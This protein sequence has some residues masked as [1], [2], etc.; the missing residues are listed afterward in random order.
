[1]DQVIDTSRVMI[2]K[3][4]KSFSAASRLFDKSRRRSA[5]MLYAWCRYCDDE[6]D[7]QTLG[8]GADADKAAGMQRLQALYRETLRALAGERVEDAVF[9]ALQRVVRDHEIPDRYPLELLE[10]FAMDVQGQRYRELG[11]TLQYCYHVAGVVGVMMAHVMGVRGRETL[12]R[13]AD[14]GI[15]FQLTNIA[16]DVLDDARMGRCYLPESWLAEEG[17]TREDLLAPGHRA[18]L[19]RVARRLLAEAERYYD[20]ANHGLARLGFRSAWAVATARRVYREIG[21]RLIASDEHAWE[22]REV[23][24]RPRKAYLGMVGGWDA[25]AAVTAGRRSPIPPREGLWTKPDP[26]VSP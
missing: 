16:R 26:A 2:R 12:N 23:V 5:Y 11:D 1:M 17:I 20:S 14:L 13:A 25:L 9:V 22:Q 24:G 4:S 6:V 3:G 10:G 7:G 15:A 19:V 18:A 8:F 21:M